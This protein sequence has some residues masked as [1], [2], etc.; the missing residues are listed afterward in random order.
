MLACSSKEEMLRKRQQQ[1]GRRLLRLQ[2]FQY[3]TV[4]IYEHT[5]CL[6]NHV[7]KIECQCDQLNPN[8]LSVPRKL[9]FKF[10]WDPYRIYTIS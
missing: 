4:H 9:K 2:T 1:V 7:N 6:Q 10:C 8:I 3:L 5:L